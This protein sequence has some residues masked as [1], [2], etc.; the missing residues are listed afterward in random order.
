MGISKMGFGQLSSNNHYEQLPMLEKH[1]VWSTLVRQS[2]KLP[3]QLPRVLVSPP[4]SQ[5]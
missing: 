5:P 1:L 4:V 3:R 2:P